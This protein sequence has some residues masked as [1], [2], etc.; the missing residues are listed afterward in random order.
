MNIRAI[1][2]AAT[3]LC[4]V[5][6]NSDN[7]YSSADD[8]DSTD[9]S[10][11]VADLE[12]VDSGPTD[13][14]TEMGTDSDAM[15]VHQYGGA[16][17]A[18]PLLSE[19]TGYGDSL[20]GD[21]AAAASEHLPSNC[22]GSSSLRTCTDASGNTYTTQRIGDFSYTDGSNAETGSSWSQSTQRIGDT[23]FTTGY[24]ADGNS[25]NSTTQRI[26]DTTF[27]HGTNSDGESFSSTCNEYGCY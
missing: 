22:V 5:G 14:E 1:A 17:A 13:S 10:V 26:G 25:W 24:D 19:T 12:Q 2:L 16:L 27:Q 8:S 23:S 21:A 6:C 4:T 3:F 20:A 11:E 7:S 18:D 15:E 9:Q